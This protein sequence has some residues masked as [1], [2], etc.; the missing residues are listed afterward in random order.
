MEVAVPPYASRVRGL[1]AVV[2]PLNILT[3]ER[4]NRV[5]DHNCA[6]HRAIESHMQCMDTI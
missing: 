1:V 3:C 4:T 6:M 2:D 5:S